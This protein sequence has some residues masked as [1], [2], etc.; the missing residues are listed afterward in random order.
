[1]LKFIKV[2]ENI[3]IN[4]DL[5]NEMHLDEIIWKMNYD[6]GYEYIKNILTKETRTLITYG[7]FDKAIKILELLCDYPK[8]LNL[9]LLST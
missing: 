2:K 5:K 1:M 3:L 9:L 7:Q 8:I 6:Q 4:K